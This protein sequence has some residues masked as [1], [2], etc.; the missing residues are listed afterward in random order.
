MNCLKNTGKEDGL[1]E[2][3]LF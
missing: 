1:T 2:L 3:L